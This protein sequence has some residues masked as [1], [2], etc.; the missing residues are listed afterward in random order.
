MKKSILKSLCVIFASVLITSCVKDAQ[1]T[2]LGVVNFPQTFTSS[3]NSLVLT[4][5]NDSV[6]VMDF[7]WQASF[8]AVLEFQ[9]P[10]L[11]DRVSGMQHGPGLPV[12][13]RGC[14]CFWHGQRV[15]FRRGP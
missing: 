6:K 12:C 3:T 5:D 4:A 9:R 8:R 11:R 15:A 2:T 13:H 1:I 14:I 10:M 7:N